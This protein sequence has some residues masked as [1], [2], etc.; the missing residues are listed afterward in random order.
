MRNEQA[1]NQSCHIY[2]GK[3]RNGLSKGI[4]LTLL[5]LLC[6]ICFPSSVFADGEIALYTHSEIEV[7]SQILM[8]VSFPGVD[9][10]TIELIDSSSHISYRDT[11]QITEG[12][13]DYFYLDEIQEPG[14]YTVNIYGYIDDEFCSESFIL[15]FTSKGT[16]STRPTITSGTSTLS[17]DQPYQISWRSVPEADHYIVYLHSGTWWWRW[18]Y[19]AGEETTWTFSPEDITEYG[20]FTNYTVEV[21][22]VCPGYDRVSTTKQVSANYTAD[23]RV[24]VSVSKTRVLVGEDLEVTVQATGADAVVLTDDEGPWT[25]VE[26]SSTTYQFSYNYPGTYRLYGRALYNGSWTMLSHPI[27]VIVTQNGKIDDPEITCDLYGYIDYPHEITVSA[28]PNVQSYLIRVSD[29]VDEIVAE[30]EVQEAGTVSLDM[31]KQDAGRFTV[32]VY[33]YG[34]AGWQYGYSSFDFIILGKRSEA[35][36]VT[37]ST[38]SYDLDEEAEFTIYAEGAEK[39]SVLAVGFNSNGESDYDRDKEWT[40][41]VAENG[42]ANYTVN[43]GYS[44]GGIVLAARAFVNGW[45]S[46]A[47]FGAITINDAP[48]LATPGLNAVQEMQVGSDFSVE[49]QSVPDAEELIFYIVDENDEIIYAVMAE[50]SPLVVPEETFENGNYTIYL[51]AKAKGWQNSDAAVQALTVTG[52]RSQAPTLTVNGTSFSIRDVIVYTVTMQQDGEVYF[53]GDSLE[54][55]EW[56]YY[57]SIIKETD[58]GQVTRTLAWTEN[59]D[60]TALRYRVKAKI[61]GFWTRYSDWLEVTIHPDSSWTGDNLILPSDLTQIEDGAFEGISARVVIISDHVQHIGSRAFANCEM[62]TEVYIPDAITYIAPDA[63][64]GCLGWLTLMA[65]DGNLYVENY[66]KNHGYKFAISE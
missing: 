46:Y 27:T 54:N 43:C 57:D 36:V 5:L 11:R 9:E 24:S 34:P 59:T 58:N 8:Q 47:G 31:T 23:N 52:E 37:S 41:V 63:F 39:F 15:T 16:P 40:E 10:Y 56:I 60:V 64:E 28:V 4:I 45:W 49:F 20:L 30:W 62:L 33:A 3:L 42:F 7:N 38:T 6:F 48:K 1:M 55:G 66:A 29:E 50:E 21:I 14:E 22:A 13:D 18:W 19:V 61:N 53:E 32:Q 17:F 44:G 35:P 51:F 12:E 2:P 26:A 65:D 25:E